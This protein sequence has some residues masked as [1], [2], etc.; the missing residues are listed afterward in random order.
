LATTIAQ[1]EAQVR[2]TPLIETTASFWTSAELTEWTIKGIKDLW[3][4]IVDLKSEHYLTVNDTTVYLGA[5]SSTIS[6]VP[7]DVHKVYLIEVRDG[8]SGSSN[9]GLV[10]KPLEYN[11]NSFISARA[12]SDIDPSNDTIYYAITGQGAPVNAPVIYVAPQVTSSVNLTFSYVPTLS[13][14]ASGSTVPIPGEADNALVAWTVAFAR[15]KERDDRS[16]DPN[17]LAIYS[18]EKEHLLQSL[19]LRQYQEPMYGAAVFEEYWG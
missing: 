8:T 1:I 3:R 2:A 19:G 11:H 7:A 4:D 13:A 17:W 9:E 18:T 10:F 12:R 5:S 16:P 6:G 15:S 14:L